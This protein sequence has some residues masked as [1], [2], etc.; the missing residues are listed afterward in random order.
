MDPLHLKNR[1]LA[2]EKQGRMDDAIAD[3]EKAI[4]LRPRDWKQ[5]SSLGMILYRAKRYEE[6]VKST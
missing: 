5:Y 2:K 3:L 4:E 1:G 6:S